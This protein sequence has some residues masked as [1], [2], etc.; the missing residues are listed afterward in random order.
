MRLVEGI[1]VADLFGGKGV[2]FSV[3]EEDVTIEPPKEMKWHSNELNS[4]GIQDKAHE[5]VS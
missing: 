4:I 2:T 5:G 3:R 1:D